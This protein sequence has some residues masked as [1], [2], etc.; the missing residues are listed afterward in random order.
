MLN[1]CPSIFSAD[2]LNIWN[3]PTRLNVMIVTNI[4]LIAD[5]SFNVLYNN[6]TK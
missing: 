3:V 5:Y 6:N 4:L 1:N 2:K